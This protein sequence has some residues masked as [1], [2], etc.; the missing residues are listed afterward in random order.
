M[1]FVVLDG[2]AEGKMMIACK[3]V[4]MFFD[5]KYEQESFTSPCYR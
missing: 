3:I 5:N 4:E 2:V 1:V